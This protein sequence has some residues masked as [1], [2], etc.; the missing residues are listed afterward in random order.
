[1]VRTLVISS[2]KGNFD[3]WSWKL[4]RSIKFNVGAGGEFNSG[5]PLLSPDA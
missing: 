2:Y 1:V 3:I 4:S 5:V